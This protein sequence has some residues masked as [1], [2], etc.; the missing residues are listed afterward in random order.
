MSHGVR[1]LRAEV[2]YL[3]LTLVF[4]GAYSP[5]LQ[6]QSS[7]IRVDGSNGTEVGVHSWSPFVTDPNGCV[8]NL[9]GNIG[10]ESGIDAEG[11]TFEAVIHSNLTIVS[12]EVASVDD[13]VH[14]RFY[15]I[16]GSVVGATSGFI[17][18]SF[19]DSTGEAGFQGHAVVYVIVTDSNGSQAP[20]I[21]DHMCDPSGGGGLGGPGFSI[22][23]IGGTANPGIGQLHNPVLP[24]LRERAPLPSSPGNRPAREEDAVAFLQLPAA[25][26]ITKS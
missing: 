12:Q 21:M 20:V 1:T 22:R 15:G 25:E 11:S 24:V 14:C 6:A 8:D 10:I 4:L 2:F 17:Y 7:C 23:P 18:G 13:E 3:A 16:F 9:S 5:H 26:K 19:D